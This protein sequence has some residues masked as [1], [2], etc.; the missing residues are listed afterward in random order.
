MHDDRRRELHDILDRILDLRGLIQMPTNARAGYLPGAG[1]PPSVLV[2]D[3]RVVWK[4]AIALAADIMGDAVRASALRRLYSSDAEQREVFRSWLRDLYPLLHTRPQTLLSIVPQRELTLFEVMD[5]ISA[6]D[7]GE[8]R[9]LFLANTGKNRRANRWS[10]ARAK[11]EAL[12]WKRRLRALGYAEKS[13][14]FEVTLAFGEQWD[15]IRK[16]KAQCEQI[17]GP[18]HVEVAL[19]HAGSRSDH[20]VHPPVGI[21]GAL[22]HLGIDPMR[23]LKLAG[24]AYR[25]ELS[26]S[27][28]LTKR[29]PRAA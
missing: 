27:A 19:E 9:P 12:T 23:S 16:W 22:S 28:Q 4:A 3:A 14:N 8:I 17:L 5:A 26:R 2:E 1:P 10:L 24:S 13:A 20:Y 6:L 25:T 15:T 7:A 18:I 21:G 11:L 29:K